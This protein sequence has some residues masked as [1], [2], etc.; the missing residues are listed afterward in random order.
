MLFN[1]RYLRIVL[2]F[3]RIVLNFIFWEIILRRLGFRGLAQRTARERYTQAARRF[4]ALA[5]NMGGVLIKV[6]QFLSA[7]VDVLPEYITDELS[8]LQDEVPAEDFSAIRQVVEHE[9]EGALNE[10]FAWFDPT[11]LAAASL[12]QAHRATLPTG[13]AVVVKAQRPGIES[14]IEID[15]AALRTV[16]SWLKR[17]PP[18]NRRAD[19][20][21]LLRE[22]S[23]TLREELDY[24]AEAGNAVRFAEM[25]KDD[26]GVRIPNVY[27]SHSRRRVL[28]LESVYF[29]KITDYDAITAAGVDRAEVAERL[30]TTYLHQIFNV[31][32]FHAD[33][34]PGNLFVEAA[35]D[36]HGWRLT[37]VDFGM[38]GHITP[39]IRAA[40]REAAIA[41]GTR[42]PARLIKSFTT[43]GALRSGVDTSRIIE[44]QTAVFDKFWGKSMKELRNTRPEEVREFAHQFRDLMFELPFQVPENLIYLGRTVAILSGM[45]TGL[46]PDFNLFISLT[47]FAQTLLAEETSGEGLE[48][49]LDQLT[50]WGQQLLALP[51][52]LDTVLTRFEKGEFTVLSRPSP[53]QRQQAHQLNAALNRLTGGFMFAA[54]VIAG[55]MLYINGQTT[56][57]LA[58]W[59]L[60]GLTLIWLTVQ[61]RD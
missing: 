50:E 59:G 17:Y 52:R 37:F 10:R 40:L 9:L 11:P 54:L 7:R 58:G 8:G 6:G 34:H 61:G 4:R 20:E 12:G 42:D 49:W 14:I 30:F 5:I 22:F 25:F 43:V 32:F 18:I 31:G 57:A 24:V 47:P 35:A 3:G 28:T 56:V 38:V 46:N 48:F 29:I 23:A 39:Q 15:L 13:E 27:P 16:V 44:A 45:C 26:A 53:E 55:A 33:P 51:K 2:F 1:R 36:G 19:L 60:A 21:A 41:V